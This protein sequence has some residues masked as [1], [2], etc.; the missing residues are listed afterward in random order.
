[1]IAPTGL[2]LFATVEIDNAIFPLRRALAERWWETTNTFHTTIGEWTITPFEFAILIGIR[3]GSCL[4]DVD[5]SMLTPKHLIDLVLLQSLVQVGCTT[6]ALSQ[7]AKEAEPEGGNRAIADPCISPFDF[8]MHYRARLGLGFLPFSIHYFCPD[9]GCAIG[10]FGDAPF[11]AGFDR[12]ACQGESPGSEEKGKRRS[13]RVFLLPGDTYTD[14]VAATL[15]TW[16]ESR[17]DRTLDM[18][19]RMTSWGQSNR[20]ESVEELDFKIESETM[21]NV[22]EG[23]RARF[24]PTD[25]PLASIGTSLMVGTSSSSHAPIFGVSRFSRLPIHLRPES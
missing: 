9:Q 13:Y 24:G 18:G 14:W 1:M 5:A 15:A 17:L 25:H 11:Q 10:D 20:A 16:V 23:I 3:F 12:A 21:F 4:L 19:T 6:V 2:H 7:V 8:G 22:A